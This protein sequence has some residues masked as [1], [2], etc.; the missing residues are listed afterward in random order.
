MTDLLSRL[1]RSVDP[2]G[3]RG[4]FHTFAHAGPMFNAPIP[5]VTGETVERESFVFTD[6]LPL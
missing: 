6:L 5:I 1:P 3:E 4:E 2:C